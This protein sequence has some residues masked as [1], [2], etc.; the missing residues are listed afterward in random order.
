M[1]QS[2][3][4]KRGILCPDDPDYDLSG[5]Q[6][7]II[8]IDDEEVDEQTVG[9]TWDSITLEEMPKTYIEK[10]EKEGLSW[11][12]IYLDVNDVEPAQPRDSEDDVVQIRDELE[13]RFGWISLGEEGELIQGVV[14]SA[15]SLDERD[16][17]KAWKK[18]F[19]EFLH[20]PFGT[21]IERQQRSPLNEGDKLKV[22]GIELVDDHHGII[23]N[24]MKGSERY[25]FPLVDLKIIADDPINAHQVQAY[26]TWFANR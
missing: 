11:S 9:I 24:C 19:E 20:F 14:N 15:E 17:M 16:V 18:H 12:D 26:C 8:D 6:G 25:D 2:V 4:V 5:W 22:L 7:R 1:G 21:V 23:V 10:S 13:A 3:R